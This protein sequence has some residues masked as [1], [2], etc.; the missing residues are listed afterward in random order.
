MRRGM[1]ILLL[2]GRAEIIIWANSAFVAISRNRKL[3][4]TVTL[5]IGMDVARIASFF[6]LTFASFRLK[7]WRAIKITERTTAKVTKRATKE[8][9]DLLFEVV[10]VHG[11]QNLRK[12]M[13]DILQHGKDHWNKML[14]ILQGGID[15]FLMLQENWNNL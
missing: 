1:Q 15:L 14:G 9:L 6:R 13:R 5:D 4:A 12:K 8:K 11:C 3:A 7:L 10:E 2:A